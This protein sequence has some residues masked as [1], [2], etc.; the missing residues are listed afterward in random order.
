MKLQM[1]NIHVFSVEH[2]NQEN[3]S[4]WTLNIRCFSPL[5]S[6]KAYFI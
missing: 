4:N 6:D 5:S 2:P 3:F 1:L